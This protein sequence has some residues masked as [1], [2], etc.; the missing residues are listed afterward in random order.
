MADERII[1]E[2]IDISSYNNT[3][4]FETILKISEEKE[5]DVEDIYKMLDDKLKLKIR[6]EC[7]SERK[8]LID[9]KP[10]TSIR[11]LFV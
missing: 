1:K 4:V 7:I 6:Q 10:K 2:I 5:I 3:T 8:V 9:E 11:S